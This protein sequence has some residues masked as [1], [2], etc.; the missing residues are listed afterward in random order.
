[1]NRVT[2]TRNFGLFLWKPEKEECEDNTLQLF[3]DQYELTFSYEASPS[4]DH[5][6]VA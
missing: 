4:L 1:M 2:N 3:G 6:N 5:F